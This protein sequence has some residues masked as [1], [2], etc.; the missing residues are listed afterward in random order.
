MLVTQLSQAQEKNITGKVIDQNNQPIIGASVVIKETGVG[1]Q[2]DIDGSFKIKANSTQTLVISYLGSKTKEI[3]AG[4]S[5]LTVKLID[6]T[7]VIEGIVIT[8]LGIKRKPD[9]ITAQSQVVKQSELNQAKVTNPVSG[10][11]GKVSGLQINTANNGVNPSTRIQLRGFRSITGNN[12]ALIVINGVVSTAGAFAELNPESIESVNVMKGASGSALYG[13][14]GSNGVI[15]VTTKKGSKNNEKFKVTLN[16][17]FT[18]DE[19]AYTPIVQTR[20]GQGYQGA[21]D[22]TENTN[23]GPELD[24]SLQPTGLAQTLYPYSARKNN[25]RDFFSSGSTALNSITLASGDENGYMNLAIGNQKTQGIV[26]G[27][28]FKKNNFNLSAGKTSGKLTVNGNMRYTGSTEDTA[29]GI[30]G[31][32][33][34]SLLQVP[35]NVPVADFSAG[36]NETHWTY[37]E[38]SPYWRL[39]NERFNT[40]TQTFE[41][42]GELVYKFNNNINALYR[43]SFRSSSQNQNRFFNGYKQP[44]V[45]WGNPLDYPS[46]YIVRN[47]NSRILYSDFMF[48]FDYNLTNDITF[49]ANI[50]NNITNSE[51]NL[52]RA[53]GDNLV[54]PGLY[55]ISNITGN[56]ELVDEKIQ[57]RG[58]SFFTN[59]DFG[60]KEYL[61]LNVTGRKEWTS[62]LNPENRT[63]NYWSSGLS[64][65]PT[66]AFENFGG[67]V[68]DYLKLSASIVKVG[69][70]VVNPYET[71]DRFESSKSAGFPYDELNSFTQTTTIADYDLIPEST[72]SKELNLSAEFLKRR[73]TFDASYYTS[74]NYDQILTSSKSTASGAKYATINSGETKSTGLELDLGITPIKTKNFT[75]DFKFNYSAPKTTVTKVSENS[76]EVNVGDPLGTV[77]IKAIEGE[78]FPMI[79]GVGYLRDPNGNIIIDATTGDPLKDSNKKLG[80]T[81]PDYILGLSTNVKYKNLR[82]STV[83]DYRT[84]HVFYA[85]TKDALVQNGSDV[86]TAENGRQ[87]FIFP[88]SVIETSPGVYAANTSVATSGDQTYYTGIYREIDENFVVDATAFKCREI[89]LS[90]DFSKKALKNTFLD[91]FSI[92]INA[93]NVFMVLPKENRNYSDPE[94]SF[95]TGNN[96][97]LSTTSQGPSTRTY[98]FNVNIS[99]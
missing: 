26:P 64:F 3:S 31:D 50:G 80:K 54:I 57:Q 78:Q 94:F 45:Y 52:L 67:D 18:F 98:G 49:K 81:T 35:V 77:G 28:S 59:L 88:N 85:G 84:G 68:L 27:D 38:L 14:L 97:G 17:T 36:M 10:L 83:F 21:Q 76:K 90:Y 16:S 42:V 37:W 6:E 32:I 29:G 56:A 9:E 53:E 24:G 19:L 96:V 5:N 92:G 61:F 66:K 39:K 1:T 69:N 65:I 33:Y 34:G 12:E 15:I 47:F 4:S 89:A 87:P 44:V 70:A 62:V 48:N 63:F 99:F 25:L 55:N 43:G 13:S 58:F 30:E 75:W 72:I 40:K 8:A 2:T 11:V 93:R 41:G 20:F 23:W 73:I 86:V 91:S 74:R 46:K 82:L 51:S 71:N 79:V 60:Y 22:F 95:S 7:Q